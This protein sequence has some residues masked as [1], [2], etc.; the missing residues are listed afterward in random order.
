VIEGAVLDL[1]AEVGAALRERGET[2]AVAEGACG[3][4]VSAALVAVPGASAFYV[5]GAVIYTPA[6][7]AAFLRGAIETPQNL[8]GATEPF[9]QYLAESVRTKL[10]TTWGIGEGGAAGPS[11]NPYGDP[12]GH[13]WAA[14]AGPA[15][16]TSHVLTGDDSRVS[17]MV[18]FAM[19]ALSLLRRQLGRAGTSPTHARERP[20]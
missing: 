13:M 11:G 1:A 2:V 18:A 14:V 12:P 9:A 19:E 8:R 5:G 6:A 3:G 10:G 7:T 4:L 16:A 17:N 15:P 20:A